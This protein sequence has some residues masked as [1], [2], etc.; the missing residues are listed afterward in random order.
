MV[1]MD[2]DTEPSS[3]SSLR[4]VLPGDN[5]RQVHPS[6]AAIKLGPGVLQLQMPLALEGKEEDKKPKD[7]SIHITA[8]RSG[9]L[10]SQKPTG[11]KAAKNA[12]E[13]C[14]VEARSKRVSLKSS[15]YSM[16]DFVG[17]CY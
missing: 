12:A 3:S 5:A 11:K 9:I 6:E 7:T 15:K 16:T 13:L 2:T 8:T 14:W 17:V 1:E 4:V 10:G